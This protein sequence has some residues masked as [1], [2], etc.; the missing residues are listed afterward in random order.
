MKNKIKQKTK[1]SIPLWIKK[2]F[3]YNEKLLIKVVP[4]GSL[5]VKQYYSIQYK[6][7]GYKTDWKRLERMITLFDD[8][9]S[10]SL[11]HPCLFNDFDEAVEKAKSLTEN[12]IIAH[13][14]EQK[15]L[16]DKELIRLNSLVKTPKSWKSY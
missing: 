12:S 7:S 14:K 1:L 13:D 6:F 11:D 15:K 10:L 9:K 4:F 3:G 8:V 5:Y 2:L 16:Y